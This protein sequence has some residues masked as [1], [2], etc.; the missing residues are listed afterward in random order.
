MKKEEEIVLEEQQIKNKQMEDV[1]N[2]ALNFNNQYLTYLRSK[3][4]EAKKLRE[5][6]ING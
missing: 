2:Q 6:I 1:L 5:E 4:N 3:L